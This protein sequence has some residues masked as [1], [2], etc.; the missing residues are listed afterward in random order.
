M[1][2]NKEKMIAYFIERC[3]KVIED[4]SYDEIIND[5]DKNEIGFITIK[6]K[7]GVTVKYSTIYTCYILNIGNIKESLTYNEH[8]EIVKS[9]RKIFK[10][11]IENIDFKLTDFENFE[12]L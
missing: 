8:I 6:D 11:F 12:N 7:L 3:K 5:N 1:I 2:T 4:K 10:T 9:F